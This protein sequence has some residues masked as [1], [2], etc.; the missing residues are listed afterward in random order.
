VMLAHARALREEWVKPWDLHPLY[1][2]RPD[3][4]INWVTRPPA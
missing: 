3:A 4:E 2:R 1:L